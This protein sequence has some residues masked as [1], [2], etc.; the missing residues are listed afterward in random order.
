[1]NTKVEK[2]KAERNRL[3]SKATAHFE[4]IIAGGLKGPIEVPEWDQDVY[5]KTTSSMAEEARVIELTQAGKTTEG[6]VVQLIIKALDADGKHLF[7]MGDKVALM[8]RVDP[9]VILRVVTSM[10]TGIAEEETEAGN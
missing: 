1:M 3:I 5:Y 8:N 10:K 4:T 9:A 7:D 2:H 6:L